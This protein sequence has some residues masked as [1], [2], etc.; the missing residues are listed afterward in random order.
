VNIF[1]LKMFQVYT[2]AFGPEGSQGPS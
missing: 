1:D 2:Y